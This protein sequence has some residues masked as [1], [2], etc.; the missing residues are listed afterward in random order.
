MNI[1][2]E[3]ATYPIELLLVNMVSLTLTFFIAILFMTC[4]Y[5]GQYVLHNLSTH[6]ANFINIIVVLFTVI[7]VVLSGS[8]INTYQL[9]SSL[10][11]SILAL[12]AVIELVLLYFLVKNVDITVA[13]RQYG[14][15]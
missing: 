10:I 7:M 5:Y 15:K 13:M 6:I 9:S 4:F 11:S 8:V 2:V 14:K 3:L 1:S 12:L